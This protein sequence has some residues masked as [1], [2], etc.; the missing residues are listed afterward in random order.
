ML[1]SLLKE[2]PKAL[3]DTFKVSI[4]FWQKIKHRRDVSSRPG[5]RKSRRAR[6]LNYADATYESLFYSW[7]GVVP[8]QSSSLDFFSLTG[9]LRSSRPACR[10]HTQI[11]RGKPLARM[12]Y[13]LDTPQPQNGERA[14]D[15]SYSKTASSPGTR[16]HERRP[17]QRQEP[18]YAPHSEL[19]AKPRK[20]TAIRSRI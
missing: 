10:S 4:H 12:D 18:V 15:E 2:Q 19:A 14:V 11:L 13:N 20:G 8:L 9:V 16:G 7:L 6:K 5:W 17:V 3:K 1:L